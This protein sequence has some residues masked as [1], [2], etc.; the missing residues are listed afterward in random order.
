MGKIY[1]CQSI[2]LKSV[3]LFL[4]II[5]TT[6]ANCQTPLFTNQLPDG[7]DNNAS[8]ELGMRFKTT[9]AG[10]ITKIRYYKV[11]TTFGDPLN[12]EG[13]PLEESGLHLGRIGEVMVK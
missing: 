7:S 4:L 1:N 11:S 10:Q 12:P 2:F 5:Y 3:L 6:N 9:E 8:Y 13:K